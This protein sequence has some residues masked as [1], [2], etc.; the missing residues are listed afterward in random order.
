M[1]CWRR[2]CADSPSPHAAQTTASWSRRS[3]RAT[4]ATADLI[5]S[6]RTDGLVISGPR[7]DDPDL[8]D[9]VRDG[10]PVVLQGSL[11]GLD[12]PSVDVDNIAGARMAVEHLVALGHRRIAC[13]TNAPV[14]YTAAAE[15]LAG[16]RLALAAAG[17]AFDPILVEEGGFDAPSGHRAM[18]AILGRAL[19]DAVFVASDVV[20][21]GVLAALRS[22]GHAVPARR[23]G[24]RLRR[25]PT[26]G[27][28]RPAAD[29][30]PPS[31]SRARH[32]GGHGHPRAHRRAARRT[33]IASAN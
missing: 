25:H 6:G 18:A 24:G 28:R 19:P 33:S 3:R 31:R 9:L 5:R 23:V 1:R 8:A 21:L 20:A 7:L 13:I 11:P 14:V 17:I 27:V 2:R 15:R 16:Y 30:G 10:F 26:C 29:H 32:R 4:A 12:A 22:A